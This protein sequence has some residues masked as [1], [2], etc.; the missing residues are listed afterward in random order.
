MKISEQCRKRTCP[1]KGCPKVK[2]CLSGCLSCDLEGHANNMGSKQK[3]NG[4]ARDLFRM[5]RR[6]MRI[7]LSGG[8]HQTAD[9]SL[10]HM[11]AM[12]TVQERSPERWPPTRMLRHFLKTAGGLPSIRIRSPENLWQSVPAS[13]G[14]TGG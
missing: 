9:V 10:A 6:R 2:E 3:M 1:C 5:T 11:A 13:K 12:Q 14:K 7:P 8:F 4:F